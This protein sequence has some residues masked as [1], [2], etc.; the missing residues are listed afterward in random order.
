MRLVVAMALLGV[1][2]A[3]CYPEGVDSPSAGGVAGDAGELPDATGDG[4]PDEQN[5]VDCVPETD[6]ELCARQNKTCGTFGSNDNCGAW[7]TIDDCGF[8]VACEAPLICGWC[9]RC[10]QKET[11]AEFCAR[12]GATCGGI[13][14]PDN[15]GGWRTVV[16]CGACADA[17]DGGRDAD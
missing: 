14:A 16:S 17:G 3:G 13:S 2:I 9:N 1:A 4:A 7:R 10:C 6:R 8:G 11:D 12:V 15:C 5:A